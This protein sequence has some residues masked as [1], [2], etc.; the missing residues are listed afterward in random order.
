MLTDLKTALCRNPMTVVKDAAGA[1][2]LV[3]ILVMGLH[4]PGLY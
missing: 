1:V 2:S 3:V 4:L